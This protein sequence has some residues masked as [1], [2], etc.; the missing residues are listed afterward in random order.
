MRQLFRTFDIN[1]KGMF[2]D[3]F[4]VP[5]LLN[6]PRSPLFSTPT[7][8]SVQSGA[9]GNSLPSRNSHDFPLA[10]SL[11][12]C[13]KQ[14]AQPVEVSRFDTLGFILLFLLQFFSNNLLSRCSFDRAEDLAQ[15]FHLQGRIEF[16]QES[17]EDH[18]CSEFNL[19]RRRR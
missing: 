19:I 18:P 11:S 15:E 5:P 16:V 6:H 1:D 12:R 2:R 13:C 7:S 4:R 14:R 10:L 8:T 17:F 9:D 3:T